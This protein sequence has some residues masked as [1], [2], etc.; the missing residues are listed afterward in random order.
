MVKRSKIILQ[1]FIRCDVPALIPHFL[2]H[3]Q[4]IGVEEFLI[5]LR[6]GA[7]ND[8]RLPVAL[9]LMRDNG[10]EP[11]GQ[12]FGLRPSLEQM[13]EFSNLSCSRI[14]SDDW[15]ISAE[16]NELIECDR[17]ADDPA[18]FRELLHLC[19]V[20]GYTFVRGQLV[21][22]VAPDGSLPAIRSD[23][24]LRDQFGI[25]CNISKKMLGVNDHRI[26]ASRGFHRCM[27]GVRKITSRTRRPWPGMLNVNYFNWD[28]TAIERLSRPL[29][30]RGQKSV[31]RHNNGFIETLRPSGRL[32]LTSIDMCGRKSALGQWAISPMLLKFM[33]THVPLGSDVLELGSGTGTDELGRFYRMYSIEHDKRWLNRSDRTQYINAPLRDGWYDVN[34]VAQGIA[35]LCPSVILVD[36]PPS[37]VGRGGFGKNLELFVTD[38]WLIFDDVNRPVDHANYMSV[39][40]RFSHRRNEIYRGPQKSF[41]VIYPELSS[42]R[43]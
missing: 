27:A 38:G 31:L 19:E 40:N 1:S 39:C 26:I 25:A 10:I 17:F 2:K 8:P 32:D 24:P 42:D 41:G 15:A 22:M 6:A 12:W 20:F 16:I 4:A 7:A 18:S 21:D 5:V 30:I 43:K 23:V 34:L 37:S 33:I 9:A 36:G 13:E 11:V 29:T 14:G 35:G 3:Y 28:E